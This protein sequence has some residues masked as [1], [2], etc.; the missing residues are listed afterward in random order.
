ME[1][2]ENDSKSNK[3]NSTID[4][5][6]GLVKAIPVYN[7]AIQPAAKEIGKSLTTVSKAINV[8]LA[9]ISV[10]IWGYEKI[11]VFINQR[12]VEKLRHIP[13]DNIVTPDPSVVGPALEALRF[14]GN[15]EILR[16]LYANLIATS[17]DKA[18]IL[19]AHPGFV[20]I[21]KNMTADEALILKL[22]INDPLIPLVDI[23]INIRNRKG[24]VDYLNNY[25]NI[26]KD[27]RCQY[28][29]LCP[30]YINNLCRLGLLHIPAGRSLTD[31]KAYDVLINRED[32]LELKTKFESEETEITCVDKYIQLTD[33]G[34]QFIKACII[35]KDMSS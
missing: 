8:A 18:T 32:F 27:A 3:F 11:S 34:S 16:E 1:T 6:T 20:E 19:N 21:I 28:E 12:L 24:E 22:F 33:F 2:T 29:D 5:V 14:S 7:D 31:P 15:N 23:K 4:T 26:G 9:P 17:M 10:L 13:E 30:E 35:D 25:S